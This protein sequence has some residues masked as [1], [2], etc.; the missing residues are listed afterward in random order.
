MVLEHRRTTLL[1]KR[2]YGEPVIEVIFNRSE[3]EALFARHGLRVVTAE[4]SI[5]YDVGAIVGEPT[6]T[7][8]Y[9]CQ[10]T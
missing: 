7:L 3:L 10:P 8:T 6:R 9:L 1:E 2:A 4:E 5:P